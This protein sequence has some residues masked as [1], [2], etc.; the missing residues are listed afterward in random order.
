MSYS[1]SYDPD[2]GVA[3]IALAG[4]FP[5]ARDVEGFWCN[6]L[7]GE[8]TISRF[9]DEELDPA[10]WSDIAD[11]KDP[12]YVRA[13]G[14]LED[15]EMF[16][17][18]F[19]NISPREA[20][21]TD[22][23]QRL[24]LES[25]WEAL[26]CAGYDP[27]VF[28]GAIGVFA[29]MSN[30][31]YYRANLLSRQDVLQ[32]A[33]EF[34]MLGN[35][36]D[37]LATRVSY[38]LN[39]RGPSLNIVT[40]C[41]TSLVAVCQAVQS[42]LTHQCDMALAGGVSVSVPQRRG[43]TYQEGFITSPDGHCRA[44]DAKAQ[45]T[46]FSNGLGIVVLKRLQDARADGDLIYAVIK[47]AAVNNDGS[48]RVSF[49][50]PSVDGQ[51]EAIAMAQAIAGIDPA[52]ISYV[53]AHGTGTALGDPVEIAGLTKAFRIGTDKREFCAIGSVKTNIGHLDA[54]AGVTGLIK[55]TLAL[56]HKVL[57]ATLHFQSPNPRLELSETPFVV[58][59]RLHQWPEGR[60]PRRAGV[61]SLGAG[62]TNAHVVLEEAS[63]RT[64]EPPN[65]PEQLLVLSARTAGALQ[66]A[67]DRLRRY[68]DDHPE[69]PLADAAFTLQMGRRRFAHRRALVASD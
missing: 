40:A 41:S 14:I 22:P 51:A 59:T 7:E 9:T 65:R 54:A 61:S 63:E 47:G 33:G 15:V 17:A 57:P 55:T 49:T 68:L 67:T 45:G 34:P 23:Q 42:L 38:K 36:K 19:F 43:Y 52:T 58:N 37:Y 32:R 53:E 24:F 60:T 46:V 27:E 62:G 50:A 4:R 13:R 64:S 28:P 25:A 44:F 31:T 5:G 3:I 16:D 18:A 69:M 10:S 20:E 56:Y 1:D 11:R 12:A 6:L 8:E 66:V 2:G 30:N 39:L 26:E 48:A 35:E 29:G 21:V